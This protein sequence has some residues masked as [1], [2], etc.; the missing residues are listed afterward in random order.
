MDL[1]SAV[2]ACFLLTFSVLR[3]S[4]YIWLPCYFQNYLL[5]RVMLPIAVVRM[6]PRVF[7]TRKSRSMVQ[8]GQDDMPRGKSR[9]MTLERSQG[10][11]GRKNS[12][13]ER[14]FQV[15]RMRE[16]VVRIVYS[17]RFVRGENA[18]FLPKMM[19]SEFKMHCSTEK[20]RFSAKTAVQK[21]QVL[22]FFS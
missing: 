11:R 13:F 19:F 7:V 2:V 14:R 5:S 10:R 15:L 4:G 18:F 8:C 1:F 17:S 9:Q 20:I 12:L 6:R 21:N 3:V 16:T 22:V